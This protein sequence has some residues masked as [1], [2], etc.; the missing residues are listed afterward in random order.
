[1]GA[2]WPY[3]KFRACAGLPSPFVTCTQCSPA[4]RAVQDCATARSSSQ[5]VK[6]SHYFMGASFQR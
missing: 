6:V 5:S 4:S 2:S 1:M 3:E